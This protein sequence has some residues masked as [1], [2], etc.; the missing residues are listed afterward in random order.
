MGIRFGDGIL[1]HL[2]WLKHVETPYAEW[3]TTSNQLVILQPS[4]VFWDRMRI[5]LW[6]ERNVTDNIWLGVWNHGN[7]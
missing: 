6:I 4:T 7:L 2:R 5:S 3:E 1:H